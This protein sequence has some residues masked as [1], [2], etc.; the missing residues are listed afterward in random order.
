[1]SGHL[2]VDRV[3]IAQIRK[4]C[5][6]TVAIDLTRMERGDWRV[7][8]RMWFTDANGDLSPGRGGFSL[9]V[10]QLSELAAAV[11]AAL[12]EARDRALIE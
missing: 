5:R 9:P 12:R 4:N 8:F 3:A 10:A 6:E 1:M 2:P 7:S 11:D